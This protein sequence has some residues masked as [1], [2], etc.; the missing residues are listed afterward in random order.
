M[1][2]RKNVFSGFIFIF[3]I[4]C[5]SG[6]NL[7]KKDLLKTDE[8]SADSVT[9]VWMGTAGLYIS[10][11]E[12][13]IYIDPYTSRHGML[14]VGLGFK[15]ESKI[16]I[17][18]EWIQKTGGEK[19]KAVVVTHSHFDHSMDAPFFAMQTGAML[20][21]SDSTA[22]IGKGAGLQEDK[23]KIVNSGDIYKAGKFEILFIE[24]RHGAFFFGR[25]PWRGEIKEP[26]LLP[27]SASQYKAGKTF[28]LLV[29]HPKGSFL[30]NGSAGFIPGYLKG[31]SA[32][33]VMLGIGGRDDSA[34]LI[35]NVVKPAGAKILIPIHFDDFF[36][37]LENEFSFLINV[38]Y[39]E[40]KETALKYKADFEVKTMPVGESVVLFR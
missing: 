15:L 26:L 40:F 10:D 17:V 38:D 12:T 24:S 6:I 1:K 32:D 23:I 18:K 37:L 4:N 27:A 34:S 35:E 3:L 21:G 20:V 2:I 16:D 22:G 5:C 8:A 11:G 30:H 33:I 14:K 25:V 39:D 36:S 9:A 19:A 31:Y 29:R 13:G 28:T 7:Y